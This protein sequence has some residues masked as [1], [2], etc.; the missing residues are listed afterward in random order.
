[1]QFKP[2]K[3]AIWIDKQDALEAALPALAA[4]PF[5][6]VD[7]ES[8]SLYAY[9]EQVCLIQ[10]STNDD[11]YLI[12]GLAALDLAGLGDIFADE[13]VQKI[14]HAAEYDVICLRRDYGFTFNNLF[15][16]MQAARILG[17]Q[18]L[19]LS[20]MLEGQFRLEPVKSFQK[21][22]W[23]KRPLS[24]EMKQYARVDTH[25][26]IALREKLADQLE[27][28]GLMALAEEDFRRLSVSENNQHD[29]SS[30]TQVRGYHKLSPRELAVLDALCEF[31][32]QKAKQMDRPLF[33]VIGSR[34]LLAIAQAMPDSPAGLAQV[35]DLPPR[36]AA[37]YE[38]GLLAAVKKGKQAPTIIPEKHKR[39]SNAYLNRLDDLKEWRKRE[40]K[41][42]GVASDIILPRDILEEITGAHP[43]TM[44]GLEAVMAEVP[45]RYRHFGQA[46]MDVISKGS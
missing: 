40:G 26:L 14:F 41:K 19:G 35:N 7:T 18:L 17:F 33:K 34:A 8:N 28:N 25:Y 5:L 1:M 32:D 39:P 16:T 2:S 11:D 9:Q 42:M 36:L 12:D 24:G 31:R 15:D 3:A 10:C 4:G 37:R 38:K 20:A 23:G 45:W 29:L 43:H 27:K 22:N 6:A 30:Y 46:I 21:A 44:D 13:K